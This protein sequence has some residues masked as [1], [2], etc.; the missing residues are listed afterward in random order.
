LGVFKVSEHSHHLHLEFFAPQVGNALSLAAVRELGKIQKQ[1]A[2]WTKPVLVSS[3]HPT[4]FCSGGNLSDYQK[5]KTRAP[6]LKVNR[7]IQA[8]L[9]RFAKWPVVK[10]AIIEGDVLGGGMEWLA[11]F[12]FRWST[13]CALFAFWQGRIG[14]SFGWGGGKLWSEKIGQAT[15][16]Q[17]LSEGRLL[18][19]EAALRVGLVDRLESTWQ[20]RD[21]A[22]AWAQ[23]MTS[24]TTRN[25]LQW[26]TKNEAAIFSS[27]WMAPA[28]KAV[29]KKWKS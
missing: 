18:S 22:E 11:H 2:R 16:R 4:L 10:L 25:L 26:K 23:S 27:L 17:L 3:A 19:A 8:G 28:H 12:D 7:E 6:G 13:P 9:K 14:L 20:I 29:L 5:L 21:S 1:Y 15:T 24:D